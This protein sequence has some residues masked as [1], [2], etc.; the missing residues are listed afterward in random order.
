MFEKIMIKILNIIK[1]LILTIIYS[2]K[3]EAHNVRTFNKYKFNNEDKNSLILVEFNHFCFEQI[4]YWGQWTYKMYEYWLKNFNKQ[5][6]DELIL[7]T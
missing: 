1:K 6:H 4:G 2:K 3:F 7:L 5:K